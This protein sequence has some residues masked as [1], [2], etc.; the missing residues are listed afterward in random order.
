MRERFYQG[1]RVRFGT[2]RQA[3]RKRQFTFL[4]SRPYFLFRRLF[5]H[6]EAPSALDIVTEKITY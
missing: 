5:E 3:P 4:R 2:L 1:F 6:E